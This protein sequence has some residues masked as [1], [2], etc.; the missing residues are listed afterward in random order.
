M[1]DRLGRVR[2]GF[3]ADLLVINGNPLENLRL[4]NPYPT[5]LL[6]YN[7]KIINNYSSEVKPDDPNVKEVLGG[8]I[9]WTIKDGIP[10][11]VPTLMKEVKEIVTKARAARPGTTTQR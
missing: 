4:M 8:G 10:Y 2:A 6:S 9:E 5:T 3:I 1:A 7:G 11:S